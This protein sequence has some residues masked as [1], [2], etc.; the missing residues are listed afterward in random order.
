MTKEEKIVSLLVYIQKHKD[1]LNSPIPIKRQNVE[2]AYKT[3]LKLEIT[4]AERS[5][6]KLK[7]E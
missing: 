7:G 5:I 2:E 4:K 6:K 1:R 3:Y